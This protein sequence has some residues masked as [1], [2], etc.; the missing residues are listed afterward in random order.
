MALS[1]RWMVSDFSE[2]EAMWTSER[3]Q[4][5]LWRLSD[6]RFMPMQKGDPPMAVLICD[7]D[8]FL[9]VVSKMLEAGVEVR[10]L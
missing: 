10:E 4:Y 5:E 9:L 7:E 3:D 8:A 2:F 6:D 1:R